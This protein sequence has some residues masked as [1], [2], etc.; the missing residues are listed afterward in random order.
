MEQPVHLVSLDFQE[1]MVQ[2]VHLVSLDSQEL[3]E[4]PV[5]LVSPVLVELMEQLEQTEPQEQVESTEQ[6][7]QLER[8]ENAVTDRSDAVLEAL[9][10]DLGKPPV[11]AY[12]ELVGV[13]QEIQLARRQ[14][15]RWMAPRKVPVPANLLPGHAQVIREPLG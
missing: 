11:E 9:A 7:E 10:T 14:L 12:F 15:R 4:Q 13:R 6:L 2:P 5:H 8:L 1:L 3:M